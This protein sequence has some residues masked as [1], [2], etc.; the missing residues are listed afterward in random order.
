MS[1]LIQVIFLAEQSDGEEKMT[2]LSYF[3][4]ELSL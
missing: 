4:E 3:V 2:I 1:E